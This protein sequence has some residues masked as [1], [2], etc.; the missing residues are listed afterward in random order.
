[1]CVCVAYGVYATA[2]NEQKIEKSQGD[3]KSV[4]QKDKTSLAMKSQ[5]HL[6]IQKNKPLA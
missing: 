4:L 6:H 5:T 2:C 3:D 1:M